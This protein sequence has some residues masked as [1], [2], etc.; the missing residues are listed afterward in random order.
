MG[1]QAI[2]SASSVLGF[3]SYFLVAVVLTAVSIAVYAK[4]T[5]YRE[6]HLI[7]EGN[8]SAACSFGGTLLGFAVPLASAIAHSAG[9]LDMIVW[10]VIALCIQLLVYFAVRIS[11][12]RILAEIP[13]NHVAAGLLLGVL[14]LGAGI[15][16]A[17]CMVV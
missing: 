2:I 16:N 14:S 7:S 17:A 15:L 6:F 8:A 12:P 3:I 5:P 11:M 9:I 1:H 4:I 13:A 10:G